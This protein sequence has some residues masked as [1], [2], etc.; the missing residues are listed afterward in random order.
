MNLFD[1]R[2]DYTL[3]SDKLLLRPLR[4]EDI[5]HL[6]PISLSE[7]DLWKYSLVDAAGEVGLRQYIAEALHQKEQEFA[8]PFIV[9][10]IYSGVYCGCT[11]FYDIQLVH[12][13]LQLGY[14]WYAKAF[15]RTH[16]NTHAKYLLLEFAFERIMMERVEFRA[17]A[18]NTKSI[19]AMMRIGA[20]KEGILRSH[21]ITQ[22]GERRDSIVLSILRSEWL[23]SVKNQLIQ[24]L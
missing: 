7:P 2:K 14:T 6:L 23:S 11:R 22:T 12:K 9:Q 10:D 17:D 1:F 13:S 5:S 4:H 15:Q 21:M 16:V 8:Y 24:K 20:V 18:R 3:R 19:A